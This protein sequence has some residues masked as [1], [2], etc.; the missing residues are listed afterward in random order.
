MIHLTYQHPLGNVANK[1]IHSF[2]SIEL[3]ADLYCLIAMGLS[4]FGLL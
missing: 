2:N 4:L 1:S 3:F